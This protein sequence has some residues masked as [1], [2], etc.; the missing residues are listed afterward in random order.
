MAEERPKPWSIHITRDSSGQFFPY[1]GHAN[2]FPGFLIFQLIQNAK[3]KLSKDGAL[4]LLSQGK[5]VVS[6]N[7]TLKNRDWGR[8]DGAIIE[9]RFM[10]EKCTSGVYFYPI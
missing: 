9:E 10:D 6:A 3:T 8:G 1:L 5:M 2:H 7:F 4:S